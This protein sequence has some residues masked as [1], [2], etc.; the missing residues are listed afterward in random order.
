M[1]CS[2]CKKEINTKFYTER[3]PYCKYKLQKK[4]N[5]YEKN[6]EEYNIYEI[7]KKFY[8]ENSSKYKTIEYGKEQCGLDIQKSKEIVDYIADEIYEENNHLSY[9]EA[10]DTTFDRTHE[11]KFSYIAYIKYNWLN[12]LVRILM[13]YL[14]IKYAYFL[15][16][17][18]SGL[19]FVILIVFLIT[20]ILLKLFGYGYVPS[21]LIFRGGTISCMRSVS[22]PDPNQPHETYNGF[23]T[24]YEH[25]IYS[26]NSIRETWKY[27]YIKGLIDYECI[28]WY[29]GNV[30]K[31][32]RRKAQSDMELR[33]PKYYGKEA[34]EMF[35]KYKRKNTKK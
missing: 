6:S 17:Y 15:L 23:R 25:N 3:C 18:I 19:L 4:E 14:V 13:L 27:I 22:H 5:P 8:L 34:I 12:I 20:I 1:I 30:L 35:Y 11:F 24:T 33:I 9:E 7:L 29:Q 16:N 2:N 31:S 28:D 21:I 32:N 26:V 10:N